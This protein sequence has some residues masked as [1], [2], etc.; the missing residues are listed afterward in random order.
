M[1]IMTIVGALVGFWYGVLAQK[2]HEAENIE[3]PMALGI[4][5]TLEV[6]LMLVVQGIWST[7]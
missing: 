5:A 1:I 4:I 6:V 3:M 7:L 2:L